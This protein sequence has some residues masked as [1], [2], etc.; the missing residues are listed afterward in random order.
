MKKAE[1]YSTST[2]QNQYSSGLLGKTTNIQ[3]IYHWK[4]TKGSYM[5]WR[6]KVWL[7][8]K[9]TE[10]KIKITQWLL[11]VPFV[12]SQTLDGFGFKRMRCASRASLRQSR[13]YLSVS[14]G[15]SNIS[16]LFQLIT[17]LFDPMLSYIDRG[18]GEEGYSKQGALWSMWKWWIG[19]ACS[20]GSLFFE[21]KT[22]NPGNEVE[23]GVRIQRSSMSNPLRMSS[24]LRS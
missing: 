12:H 8:R 10:K 17:I 11:F 15:I 1:V 14:I 2:G 21:D 18:A 23:N 9:V 16:Y 7:L 24:R 13:S 3:N 4:I 19:Q 22:D 5:V 20:Q 6:G